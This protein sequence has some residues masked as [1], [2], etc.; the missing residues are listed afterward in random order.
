MP[1]R[2]IRK[3]KVW[4]SFLGYVRD[5]MNVTF[6]HEQGFNEEMKIFKPGQRVRVTVERIEPS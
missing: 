1:K 5:D 3:R 4:V 6:Y 2:K